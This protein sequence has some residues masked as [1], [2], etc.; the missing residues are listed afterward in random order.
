MSEDRHILDLRGDPAQMVEEMM[1]LAL[2][3]EIREFQLAEVVVQ[4]RH[5]FPGFGDGCNQAGGDG[6]GA[7][8]GDTGKRI[9][10]LIQGEHRARQPDA[11]DTATLKRQVGTQL[12]VMLRIERIN[13][14]VNLAQML[15]GGVE[16]L[17]KLWIAGVSPGVA[18]IYP[19]IRSCWRKTTHPH[20]PLGR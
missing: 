16:V 5:R 13:I 15:R 8:T 18:R 6:T 1:N 12:P 11:L 10:G 9:P 17:L 4:S 14:P 7:G 20:L 3:H 2:G 19:N